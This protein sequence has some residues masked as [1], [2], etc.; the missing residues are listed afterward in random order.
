MKCNTAVFYDVENLTSLFSAKSN[1]TLQLDEI[2]RRILTLDMVSGISVQKAY[3]DWAQQIN[4]NLRSYV[5]QIGIEAVQIFNTNQNDKV[6]NAADVSLIID[7]TELIAR[8]PEIENYVIASGDG[9]FAFLAKKLHQHGKLVIGC[10]FDRNTNI[11]FKNACDIFLPL[12][13]TDHSLNAVIKNLNKG[14][15][16]TPTPTEAEQPAHSPA[17]AEVKIPNKLPKT[18]FS[19]VLVTSDI[20]I[21]RNARDLSSSLHV[22]KRM[23]NVLFERAEANADLEISLFKTYVDHYLP[24]FR[25]SQYGFK[26][27][28]E[29]MRFIVTASP[30]CLVLSEGTVL[31]IARRDAPRNKDD[32]LMEDI[33]LLNFT[34]NDSD[35]AK[36]LFDIQDGV[37][38]HFSLEA[39]AEPETQKIPKAQGSIEEIK[40]T[41]ESENMSPNNNVLESNNNVEPDH[42][43]PARKWIKSAL[44]RLSQEDKLTP[45]EVRQLTTEDYSLKAFGIKVPILKEIRTRTYLKEQRTVDGKVIYWKDE[46]SFNGK[47]YL[48]FKEWTEKQHRAKFEIWLKKVEK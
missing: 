10:G 42:K 29:F 4:R 13:K 7:A 12:E 46:L 2:H 34:L 44:T 32:I 3:A 47:T 27:F 24:N 43:L 11:I 48:V 30:Y 14:T 16:L 28:G 21:W 5:L 36:S 40:E 33:P 45:R 23:V 39:P 19:E 31:R 18:K 26:R 15:I 25:L 20:K 37:S 9:I 8:N 17:P 41:G 6:K 22:I 38:F 35:T 1:T